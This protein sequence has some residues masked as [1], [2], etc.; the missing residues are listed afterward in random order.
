MNCPVENRVKELN[1]LCRVRKNI[2]L[3]WQTKVGLL[4]A[5]A[6][7]PRPSC[8]GPPP[9]S[10]TSVGKLCQ[11]LTILTAEELFPI[12]AEIPVFL[13]VCIAPVPMTENHWKQLGSSFFTPFLQVFE[14]MGKLFLSLF[15]F[16]LS[17]VSSFSLSSFM[18]CSNPL[19]ILMALC[20]SPFSVAISLLY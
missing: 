6:W 5:Q 11:W 13:F 2:F 4:P 8:P 7:P 20:W 19:I 12:I 14:H 1:L 10:T 15:F 17:S 3:L 16:L 18:R 9:D